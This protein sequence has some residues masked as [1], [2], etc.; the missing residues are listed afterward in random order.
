[1]M[2]SQT[3]KIHILETILREGQKTATDFSYVSN[4][5]QYFCEL[6]KMGILFSFW[7]YKGKTKVKY[8]DI[9]NRHKAIAFLKKARSGIADNYDE[10]SA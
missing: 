1:M 4:A 2:N 3:H 6:E 5:N 9:A 7:G 8:R 10:V